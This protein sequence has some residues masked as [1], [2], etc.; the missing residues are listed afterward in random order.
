[1][2]GGFS[3][4]ATAI[5]SLGLENKKEKLY[6]ENLKLIA[7]SLSDEYLDFLSSPSILLS[8]RLS[9]IDKVFLDKVEEQVL[10][11]FKLIVE[12]RKTAIFKQA[13]KEYEKLLLER[14]NLCFAVVKSAVEL[15]DVQRKKLK[16][17]LQETLGK[18]IVLECEV[19]KGLIGGIVVTVDDK[20]YDGSI[21]KK[22]KR[23][24]ETL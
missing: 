8:E 18:T 3:E 15:S 17:K 7:D 1:M 2:T 19:D 4:Y 14:E 13:V 9:S 20:I 22:L 5:Y 12:K 23:L 16:E 6:L 11:F 21:L 24:K 10:S